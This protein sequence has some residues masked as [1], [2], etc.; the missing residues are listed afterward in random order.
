MAM[1]VDAFHIQIAAQG[2]EVKDLVL[3]LGMKSSSGPIAWAPLRPEQWTEI[4]RDRDEIQVGN[5]SAEV[6]DSHDPG[7]LIT[8][9]CRKLIPPKRNL[10][11]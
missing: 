6:L 9:R 3:K 10:T 4:V 5:G 11:T 8:F 1:A 7:P 2:T